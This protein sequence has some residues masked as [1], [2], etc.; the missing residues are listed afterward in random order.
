MLHVVHQDRKQKLYGE[1]YYVDSDFEDQL[2]D[3]IEEEQKGGHGIFIRCPVLD[4]NVMVAVY[5]KEKDAMD[6]FKKMVEHEAAGVICLLPKDDPREITAFLATD[7]WN[8]D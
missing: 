1:V 5:K 2:G 3:E 7:V 4:W 8:D 6:V